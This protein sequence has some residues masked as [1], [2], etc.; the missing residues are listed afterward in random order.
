MD[1]RDVLT[2][3]PINHPDPRVQRAGFD[4]TDPYLEQ[5][6]GPVIGPSATVLLRRL[7]TLWRERSP[8]T[9]THSELALTLGLGGSTGSNSRLIRTTSRIVRFGFAEWH[10]QGRSLGVFL[11]APGL[12]PYQLARLPHWTQRAHERLL[13]EHLTRLTER[14][15]TGP[16]V[17][18]LTARLD[19]LQRP[20]S[21]GP[22]APASPTRT[23][24]R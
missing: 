16:A 12:D 13:D 2:F 20:R 14:E 17:A 15:A 6:W 22:S 19:R 23:G 18:T 9:I 21:L 5:C 3:T 8:A 1:N 7:P 11:Q 4:L 24:G 10:E